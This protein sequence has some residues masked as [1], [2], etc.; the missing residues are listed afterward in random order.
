MISGYLRAGT[1]VRA[2]ALLWAAVITA[3][4]LTS[5]VMTVSSRE[6]ADNPLARSHV[7]RDLAGLFPWW[8]CDEGVLKGCDLPARAAIGLRD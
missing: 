6:T 3:V 5:I 1:R 2:T 7:A 4:L 8:L